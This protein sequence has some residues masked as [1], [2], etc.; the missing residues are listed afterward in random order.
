MLYKPSK[1]YQTTSPR[2]G[3]RGEENR[4]WV[5]TLGNREQLMWRDRPKTDG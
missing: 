5:K 3:T 2:Q 1:F 4:T